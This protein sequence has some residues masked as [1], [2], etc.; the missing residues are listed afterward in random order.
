M[1]NQDIFQEITN[2]VITGL[3]KGEIP[4]KS[5]IRKSGTSI[6]IADEHGHET[7]LYRD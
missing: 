4:W 5:A 7:N 6:L 1:K 2:K 3:E